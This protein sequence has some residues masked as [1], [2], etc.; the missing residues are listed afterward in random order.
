IELTERL[1]AQTDRHGAGPG[2]IPLGFGHLRPVRLEP[3]DVVDLGAVDRPPLEEL[4]TTQR[5][6]GMADLYE[7]PGELQQ[8]APTVVQVP[9][10]PADL[11]VLAVSVVVPL[12]GSPDLISAQDH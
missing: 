4:A 5:G 8:L 2:R 6:V 1:S 9:I 12:Q 3:A 10:V 11:V 7:P